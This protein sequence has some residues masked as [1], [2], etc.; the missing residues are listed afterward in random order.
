MGDMGI[1]PPVGRRQVGCIVVPILGVL[2]FKLVTRVAFLLGGCW[3]GG[4]APALSWS[5]LL[6][7]GSSHCPAEAKKEMIYLQDQSRSKLK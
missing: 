5:V 6:L 1:Y 7:V 4:C 2:A 3:A